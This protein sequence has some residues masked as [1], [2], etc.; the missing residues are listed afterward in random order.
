MRR[1]FMFIFL[2]DCLLDI[3]QYQTY[4]MLM[5]TINL[6]FEASSSHLFYRSIS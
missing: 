1:Y 5:D 3:A 4:R 6:S 2:L